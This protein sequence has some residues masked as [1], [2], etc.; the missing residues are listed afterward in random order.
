MNWMLQCQ[1][2]HRHDGAGTGDEVPK[3]SGNVARFLLVPGG[4]EFLMRVPGV[5]TAPLGDADL[6]SLLNWMLTNFDPQ[7]LPDGYQPYSEDEIREAR[8]APYGAE[9]LVERRKLMTAIEELER[10]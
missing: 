2:C 9:V 1:G 10:R 4:R 5:S 6:A 8:K 3:L 7:H